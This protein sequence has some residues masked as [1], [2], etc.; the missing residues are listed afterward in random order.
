MGVGG[1]GEGDTLRG[2]GDAEVDDDFFKG[3]VKL[4]ESNVCALGP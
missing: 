3:N 2:A 1:V 4:G